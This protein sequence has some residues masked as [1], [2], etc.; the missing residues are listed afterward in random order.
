MNTEPITLAESK[1]LNELESVIRLHGAAFIAVGDALTEIRDKKLY[2]SDYGTFEAYCQ[3]VW[4]WSG[5]RA[6]QICTASAFAKSVTT[7]NAPKTEREAR[8]MMKEA[9]PQPVQQRSTPEEDNEAE[10]E[11]THLPKGL[12]AESVQAMNQEF[13]VESVKASAKLTPTETA[14]IDALEVAKANI[15][16]LMDCVVGHS[17]EVDACGEAAG[18]FRQLSNLI[19]RYQK[20]IKQ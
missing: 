11:L 10:A 8:Q 16:Y 5:S 6:R 9:K 20:E 15:E 4:G 12:T 3:E 1:R 13:E 2:R 7:G 17:C 19:V 14:L 18:N